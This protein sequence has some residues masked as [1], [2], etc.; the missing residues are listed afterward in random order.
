MA[1]LWSCVR[2]REFDVE[3]ALS[4]IGGRVER[5]GIELRPNAGAW[6]RGWVY[7]RMVSA[8]LFGGGGGV[9]VDQIAKI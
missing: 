7:S 2:P 9:T 1:A 4:S 3:S 6:T 5:W 8:Y